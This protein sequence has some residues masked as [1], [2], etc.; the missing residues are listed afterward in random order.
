MNIKSLIRYK[1][2][3]DALLYNTLGQIDES[4]LIVDRP[5]LFGNI[6]ALLNHVYAMDLVWKC[7]LQGVEHHLQTRNPKDVP[8]FNVLKQN[9]KHLNSWYEK[10]AID[11][12]D[13]KLSQIVPFKFIGGGSGKMQINEI[14]QHV[15]N[16]GSYHRGH[17]EG[18]LYQLHIE[19]PT[20]DITVF[21]QA[22]GAEPCSTNSHLN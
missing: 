1:S 7:N 3:A 12:G 17:I 11:L 2:W 4:E 22:G 20:T 21:L 10:Y 13:D 9:Q 8:N 14:I 19:P 18:V 16:H 15:V 5:M 6:L